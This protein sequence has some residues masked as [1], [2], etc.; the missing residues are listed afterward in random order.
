MWRHARILVGDKT[1]KLK[2]PS[3]NAPVYR[4][5]WDM[6][7]VSF[8]METPENKKA[9]T[10]PALLKSHALELIS[11][12]HYP[13]DVI[14]YTDGSLN[15]KT[16]RAGCGVYIRLGFRT[17][18]KSFRVGN[19]ASSL[20]TELLGIDIALTL[21]LQH[22]PNHNVLLLSDS[23]GALQTIQNTH[24][25]DNL[26]IVNSIRDSMTQLSRI[27]FIWIPSH[28]GITGNEKADKLAKAALKR[29]KQHTK[30]PAVSKSKQAI[31]F[32][33]HVSDLMTEYFINQQD[34]HDTL[35]DFATRANNEIPMS[36]PTAALE[37]RAYIYFL[38]GYK[39]PIELPFYSE[40]RKC[41]DCTAPY[42][43]HHHFFECPAHAEAISNV[44]TPG[45]TPQEK[46]ANMT[47]ACLKNNKILLDFC[48]KHPLPITRKRPINNNPPT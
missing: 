34:S 39:L 8:T 32:Q 37:S 47:V 31:Y 21:T 13:Q 29:K 48:K 26:E 22:F 38:L 1:V 12:N 10:H 24:I 3:V 23:L 46:Y 33:Q 5:P 17:I 9:D 11:I 19:H 36:I 16:G 30:L 40:S 6:N 18:L 42:S 14:I 25:H 7:N 28:V 4:A 15:P 20:Q 2:V 44:N 35:K 41:A 43:L 45:D 27:H